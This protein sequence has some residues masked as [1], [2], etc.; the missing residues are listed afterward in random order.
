[1]E[2]TKRIDAFIKLGKYLDIVAEVYESNND[3]STYLEWEQAI[4][5]LEKAKNENGWFTA[6]SI[7]FA[8][9]SWA[10]ALT[11]DNL[12]QWTSNYDFPPKTT[13]L[14]IAV[15]MAGNIPLV[16]FHDFLSILISGNKI[17]VKL[18]S[19]DK[20]LL[21]F[22]ADFLINQE[23]EFENLIHF[24][25]EKL[26]EFDAVIA[27]G[28]D[29]SARYFEYYFKKY[30]HIIRKNRNS[31][32]VLDGTES[33]EELTLLANDIFLYF[34]LGCRNVSKLYVPENYNFNNFFE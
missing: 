24:S 30:P 34:G 17:T 27:T 15:I 26:H 31:V 2:F 22:I 11:E 16:G 21:P 8:L 32:A 19:N 25:E 6:N 33:K 10:K 20:V 14:T 1:M 12:L 13:P 5:T 29:N 9:K 18:S 3:V 4:Q 28:S 23:P 7:I